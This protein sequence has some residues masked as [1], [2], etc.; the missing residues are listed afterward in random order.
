MGRRTVKN[1]REI[2]LTEG[3][4]GFLYLNDM[5]DPY[6]QF[7]GECIEETLS[8]TLKNIESYYKERYGF[9]I[10]ICKDEFEHLYKYIRLYIVVSIISHLYHMWDRNRAFKNCRRFALEAVVD[11]INKKYMNKECQYDDVKSL[12]IHEIYYCVEK[13]FESF[14]G[15]YVD[16]DEYMD[17]GNGFHFLAQRNTIRGYTCLKMSDSGYKDI[18]KLNITEDKMSD[19]E[20]HILIGYNDYTELHRDILRVIIKKLDKGYYVGVFVNNEL[21]CE[22]QNGE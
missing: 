11:L 12:D 21:V 14:G 3:E 9:Y 17:K 20:R 1:Y 5:L 16:S 7:V 8:D 18:W 10:T 13:L 4:G 19:N 6:Y 2:L 22:V 15:D